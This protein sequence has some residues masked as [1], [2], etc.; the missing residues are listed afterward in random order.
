MEIML[1]VTIIGVLVSMSAPSFQRAVEQARADLAGANLRG[2]W[3]AQRV[4]WLEYGTYAPDLATL[5][6]S[7]LVDPT[8]VSSQT[9]YAY[10]IASANA[11][12]FTAI[13]T[14]TLNARWNGSL[15][16]DDTGQT[17]GALTSAGE[18]NIVPSYQ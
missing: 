3:S 8:I 7:G 1:V 15:I 11:S 2:I 13:A 12:A 4:Y 9:F 10:Q 18:A 17:S 5:Q 16:I 6:N 14:R